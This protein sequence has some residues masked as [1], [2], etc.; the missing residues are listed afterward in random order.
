MTDEQNNLHNG[1]IFLFRELPTKNL[2]IKGDS[3]FRIDPTSNIQIVK[4]E[5]DTLR[6]LNEQIGTIK[7]IVPD[8]FILSSRV[9]WKLSVSLLVTSRSKS[10]SKFR[11]VDD[12]TDL[13]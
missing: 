13:C 8:T 3:Y 9:L 7:P 2:A 4:T 6:Y 5:P 1:N 11:Y 10:A 12:I